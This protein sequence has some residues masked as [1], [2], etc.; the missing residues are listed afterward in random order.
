MLTDIIHNIVDDFIDSWLPEMEQIRAFDLDATWLSLGITDR[1]LRAIW[2]VED[3][4]VEQKQLLRHVAAYM[5]VVMESCMTSAGLDV[6]VDLDENSGVF[7]RVVGGE[8]LPD[9]FLREVRFES[10]LREHLKE[11]SSGKDGVGDISFMEILCGWRRQMFP[12]SFPSMFLAYGIMT[13]LSPY[14]IKGMDEDVFHSYAQHVYRIMEVIA[15]HCAAYYARCFPG[16]PLGCSTNLYVDH[17]LFPP[18]LY[19]ERFPAERG[20]SGVLSYLEENKVDPKN[21]T[22]LF[23]NMAQMPDDCISSVGIALYA[24]LSDSYGE[25]MKTIAQSRSLDMPVL[26]D[27]MRSARSRVLEVNC[28]PLTGKDWYSVN[29]SLEEARNEYIRQRKF[30]FLPYLIM[31]ESF[32]D[33]LRRDEI[34]LEFVTELLDNNYHKALEILAKAP[35]LAKDFGWLAQAHYLCAIIGGDVEL[36]QLPSNLAM[37]HPDF[38]I[39]EF[40]RGMREFFDR[41]LVEAIAILSS[42]AKTTMRD[43]LLCDSINGMLIDAYILT[44]RYDGIH[45]MIDVLKR[46]D[47]SILHTQIIEYDLCAKWEK[48]E[49]ALEIRQ[50]L[51][52]RAPYDIEV[53]LRMFV[54]PVYSEEDDSL[55]IV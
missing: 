37:T 40:V 14:M 13:G 50:E 36:P 15:V 46:T 53:F 18:M 17:L 2:G 20:V 25:P 51:F 35:N 52:S 19:D 8:N 9:S 21:A 38:V 5:C 48:Y 1:L 11:V 6:I 55:V 12:S 7:M 39:V 42:L 45:E 22:D 28:E 10:V 43:D 30:G 32:V 31:P 29:F 54:P 34:S 16:E 26:R 33:G 27:A 41:N 49:R 44:E 4:N 47:S 23:V 24:G 3:L